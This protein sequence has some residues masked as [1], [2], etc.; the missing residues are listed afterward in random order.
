MVNYRAQMDDMDF[1]VE[2]VKK[3]GRATGMTVQ[4]TASRL[5]A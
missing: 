4:G 3:T 1:V 5:S 2:L